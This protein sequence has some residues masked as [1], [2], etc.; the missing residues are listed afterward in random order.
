M[1]PRVHAFGLLDASERATL[2]RLQLLLAPR[3]PEGDQAEPDAPLAHEPTAPTAAP[4]G[5]RSS[6]VSSQP[7]LS[8]PPIPAGPRPRPE[9]GPSS[10]QLEHLC[11]RDR[12]AAANA[13]PRA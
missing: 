5:S 12:E 13:P 8:T 3:T 1:D 11:T 9:P 6:G 2:R 10:A 7:S 4:P